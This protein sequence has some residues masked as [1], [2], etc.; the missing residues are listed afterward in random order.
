[1]MHRR[2]LLAL[3]FPVCA[4][5]GQAQDD[6]PADILALAELVAGH[7]L[8]DAARAAIAEAAVAA[9]RRDPAGQARAR[10][11]RL[12]FL[13]QLNRAAPAERAR[14]RIHARATLW[15]DW[16]NADGGAA[17]REAFVLDPVIAAAPRSRLVVTEDELSMLLAANARAGVIA[18]IAPPSVDRRALTAELAREFPAW[19]LPRQ[20]GFAFASLRLA[21]FDRAWRQASALEREAATRQARRRVRQA[22]DVPL[23]ARALEATA[24][25]GRPLPEFDRMA[26]PSLPRIGEQLGIISGMSGALR[27]FNP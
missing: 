11:E 13:D 15:F 14:L 16:N 23:L 9:Q 12:A 22:Q 24:A 26:L 21:Q 25:A 8:G 17:R 2:V 18:G 19:S 27:S 1:M 3:A 6:A 20:R 4:A 10:G 7:A 5:G